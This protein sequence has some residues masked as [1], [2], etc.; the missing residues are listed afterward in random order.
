MKKKIYIVEDYKRNIKLYEALFQTIPD[1]EIITETDGL[2]GFEMIKSGDPDLIILDYKL[3]KMNGI[4][5]CKKLRKI[6]RFKNIPIIAVSS[7]PIEGEVDREATFKEAGFDLSF[8]KPLKAIEFRAI[9][10][11]LLI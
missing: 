4:E 11:E 5:I 9:L 10:N 6:E 1:V 7:T 2:K 8:S 3:P